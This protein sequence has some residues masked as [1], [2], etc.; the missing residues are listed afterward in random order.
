MYPWASGGAKAP[1]MGQ[2]RNG[3][4]VQGLHV[5]LDTRG[6]VIGSDPGHL[7]A[8]IGVRDLIVIQSGDAT[9]V[10]TKKDEAAVKQLV[11]KLKAGGLGKYL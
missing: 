1:K 5:G 6:C 4:T 2:S 8:T 9:L 11:D 3:N 7:I 10:A